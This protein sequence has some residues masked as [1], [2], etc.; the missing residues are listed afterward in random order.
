[1]TV[2]SFFFEAKAVSLVVL[3]LTFVAIVAYALWP[4]NKT[5]FDEAASLPL[6]ED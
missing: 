4:S 5:S 6:N 3:M 2:Q 1:M